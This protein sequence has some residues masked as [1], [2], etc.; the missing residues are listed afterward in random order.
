MIQLSTV[1]SQCPATM[2]RKR[3]LAS[4]RLILRT[5]LYIDR[6]SFKQLSQL[7]RQWRERKC[8]LFE[9]VAK[10]IRTRAHLIASPAFYHCA[11]ALHGQCHT[12]FLFSRCRVLKFKDIVNLKVL[13]VL[14]KIFNSM[15][16]PKNSQCLLNESHRLRSSRSQFQY[17]RNCIRTNRPTKA[18]CLSTY[19]V[20]C[21]NSLPVNILKIQTVHAFTHKLKINMTK[22]YN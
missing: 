14:F 4:C 11:T 20:K 15:P 10:G 7:G 8:P 5:N 3:T 17:V 16:I 19:G 1:A 22:S 6:Y 18:H 21:W 13:L 12:N 9:T 2:R